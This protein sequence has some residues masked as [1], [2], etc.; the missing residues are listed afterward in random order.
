MPSLSYILTNVVYFA[1]SKFIHV[2]LVKLKQYNG[3]KNLAFYGTF[4][5]ND[6][7]TQQPTAFDLEVAAVL[8]ANIYTSYMASLKMLTLIFFLG[9]AQLFLN[10]N[11][12]LPCEVKN[13]KAD[14][15]FRIYIQ[16][17]KNKMCFPYALPI[18]QAY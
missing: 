18:L 10:L 15:V 12:N 9:K 17:E 1:Q 16:R 3:N 4:T 14:G 7:A 13:V 11:T 6:N 2:H 5:A 8:D